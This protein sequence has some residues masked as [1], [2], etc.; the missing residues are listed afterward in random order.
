MQIDIERLTEDG[1][2]FAHTYGPADLSLADERARLLSA[3]QVAGHLRRKQQRV[4]A[5]GAVVTEIEVYCDRCLAPVVMPVKA[6][7]DVSYDPPGTNEASEHIELQPEDLATAVYVGEQLDLDELVRE[8]ILLAL[9]MR[10]L[11]GADCKGL[12]PT[13]A[14]NR[15]EQNCACAQQESD[16]RWAGLAALKNSR[17]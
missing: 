12:C 6:E 3:A 13:C 7:F 2:S 11:C 4:H 8:Q 17:E 14:V 1:Q 9:P 5:Q 10:S 16:P 15:N